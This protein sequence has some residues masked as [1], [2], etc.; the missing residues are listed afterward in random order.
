MPEDEG[1]ERES[2]S[3]RGDSSYFE[4]LNKT[5]EEPTR[6]VYSNPFIPVTEE[7]PTV[8]TYGVNSVTSQ[9]NSQQGFSSAPKSLAASTGEG[10][11]VNEKYKQGSEYRGYK[12]NGLR[13]GYG[14]F[15]YQD[16][17]MYEGEWK[18]N[19][20]HGR[21]KLYYQSGRLAYEGEWLNDQFS[22][23]GCLHNE[24]P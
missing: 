8:A 11:Y 7:R 17:G 12:L 14:V 2:S 13:H 1:S 22:G 10:Q 19:K 23:H 21:G 3:H 5:N 6:T 16:G 9:N 4:S 20:M 15:Y 24:Y 18:E